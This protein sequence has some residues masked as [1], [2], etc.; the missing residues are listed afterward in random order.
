MV[1]YPYLITININNI[2]NINNIKNINNI[3]INI[4]NN[5]NNKNKG[6]VYLMGHSLG[7]AVLL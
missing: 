5:N 6:P 1:I 3:N 2:N 7:A 4:N